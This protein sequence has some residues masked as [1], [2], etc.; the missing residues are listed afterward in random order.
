[1]APL[2]RRDDASHRPRPGRGQRPGR[3]DDR[4][5]GVAFAETR[6]DRSQFGILQ[7]DRFQSLRDSFQVLLR[8]LAL[9]FARFPRSFEEGESGVVRRASRRRRRRQMTMMMMREA[10]VSPIPFPFRRPAS[11]AFASVHTFAFGWAARRFHFRRARVVR[12]RPLSRP[13]P[14]SL[15]RRR[16]WVLDSTLPSRSRANRSLSPARI[17]VSVLVSRRST[18]SANACSARSIRVFS[19]LAQHSR[20][21]SRFSSNSC[22]N[23]ASSFA[24]SISRATASSLRRASVSF[25]FLSSFSA[26]SRMSSTRRSNPSFCL[27]NRLARALLHLSQLSLRTL[28]VPVSVVC[29]SLVRARLLRCALLRA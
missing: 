1:M 14:L 15:V 28:L 12:A 25:L 4:S 10:F 18:A 27:S 5:L 20:S 29:A 26:F 16:P 7:R 23:F 24:R 8:L 11:A 21:F 2:S 6:D 13:I 17:L 3:R 22:R 19:R 9:L